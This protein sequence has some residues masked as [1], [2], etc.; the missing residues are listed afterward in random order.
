ML[1]RLLCTI[2]AYVTCIVSLFI[3]NHNA[4][5]N[6]KIY[7]EDLIPLNVG[8][9][10]KSTQLIM[11]NLNKIKTLKKDL[12]LVG[13]SRTKYNI[14]SDIIE[15]ISGYT[16]YNSGMASFHFFYWPTLLPT[17]LKSDNF[18][19]V[20]FQIDLNF[21]FSTNDIDLKECQIEILN[22][23]Y[24]N[25]SS[26]PLFFKGFKEGLISLEELNLFLK[27]SIINSFNFAYL[28][29]SLK[30]LFPFQSKF[31]TG[32]DHL[33]QIFSETKVYHCSNNDG[34]MISSSKPNLEIIKELNTAN[35]NKKSLFFIQNYINQVKRKN[36]K[37][38]LILL[39]TFGINTKIDIND[40]ELIFKTPVIDMS[41]INIYDQHMWVDSAHLNTLGR[42]K[43]SEI[44][45]SKL[46]NR[47]INP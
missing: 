46:K 16:T 5:Y 39:P 43:Y 26:I 14:N 20:V 23:R 17:I 30:N 32:E 31:K 29:T 35:I 18:K 7:Y 37:P 38:I 33:A 6:G 11:Y 27:F 8:T 10:Q 42:Q 15:E 4:I 28:E 45:A 34:Y 25:F 36:L 40:L 12:I 9:T 47:I 24:N 22:G 41:N 44:L 2:F 1:N 19:N 3:L 13:N 21:L